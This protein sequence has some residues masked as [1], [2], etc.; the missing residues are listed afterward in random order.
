VVK[1]SAVAPDMLVFSG[2]AHVFESEHDCLKAIARGPF[3]KERSWSSGTRPKGPPHAETLAVTLGLEF[4]NVERWPSSPTQ[5]SQAP[6]P[7]PASAMCRPR[8]ASA[9]RSPRQGRRRDL[10]RHTGQEAAPAAERRRDQEPAGDLEADGTRDP[11][12]LHAPLR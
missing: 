11:A 6:R 5:V 7:G 8:P 10:D 1:Q 9:G 12:R 4:A 3:K 2:K